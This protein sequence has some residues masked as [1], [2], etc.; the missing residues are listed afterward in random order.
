MTRSNILLPMLMLIGWTIGI[1]LVIPLQRFRAG[2]SG[3]VKLDDFKF[4]ESSNVPLQA[5]TANRNY[6]NLLE[7]PI[8]FYILCL[9]LYAANLVDS[10][11]LILA[12]VYV[13]LRM[14]HSLVHLTV[15]VVAVRA[16]L[17]GASGLVLIAIWLRLLLQ[18]LR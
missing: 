4:G 12:W 7:A 1:M 11:S 14:L 3:E 16:L 18:V 10:L 15:N 9:T 2:R 6:M 13:G 5:S 17:F 8:L